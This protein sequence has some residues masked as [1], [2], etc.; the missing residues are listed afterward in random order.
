MNYREIVRHV[1]WTRVD[2]AFEADLQYHHAA[3][4]LFPQTYQGMVGFRLSWFLHVNPDTQF[5]RYI[6]TTDLQIRTGM[7]IGPIED[8]HAA[9]R[10]IELI[11]SCFD[12]CRYYSILVQYPN[13]KACAYK[14]MGKCPAPCDGSISIEQYRRMIQWSAQ[15][16][17]DPA[18]YIR[19]QTRRMQTAASELR[20]EVASKIKAYIDE[21][22]LLGKG[23]F[24]YAARLQD[25]QYLCFQYGPKPGTV[26]VFLILKGQIEQILCVI[27]EMFKPS[28]VMRIA[29]TRSAEQSG[30]MEMPDVERIGI[31]ANHLFT[32]KNV[33]GVFL[34]LAKVDE[35]SIAKAYRDLQ[36]QAIV[37]ESEDEG[38]VKELQA[39]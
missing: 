10:L 4:A 36:K 5:P 23:P 33:H 34:S 26:K 24:R 39:L 3:R 38:I 18:E 22:S 17:A 19:E 6:K 11:E 9:N 1:H 8:K 37:G 27:D 29:L 16:L 15:V 25:F 30:D 13:A 14:E 28:D 31:V 35:K 7:L 32:A 21:L 12:L 2:S 20:F